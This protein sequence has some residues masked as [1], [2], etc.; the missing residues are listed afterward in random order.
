M[1]LAAGPTRAS[2]QNELEETTKNLH[3][4]RSNPLS[5]E[6][7]IAK[8]PHYADYQ[9]IIHTIDNIRTSFP[10]SIHSRKFSILR[11]R[12]TTPAG[13]TVST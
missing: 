13:V 4:G 9:N 3:G 10:S 11:P 7:Y 5:H 2:R 8:H 1:N 12:Q 6:V